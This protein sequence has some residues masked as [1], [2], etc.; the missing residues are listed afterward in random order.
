[1]TKAIERANAVAKAEGGIYR[2]EALRGVQGQAKILWNEPGENEGA[3]YWQGPEADA[4]AEVR[5]AS[6]ET[7]VLRDRAKYGEPELGSY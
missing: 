6:V 1:M 5:R 2:V 7:R 3:V 4:L